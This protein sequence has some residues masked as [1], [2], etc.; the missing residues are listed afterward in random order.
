MTDKNNSMIADALQQAD[1]RL[2]VMVLYHMTGDDIWLGPDFAPGRDVKLIAD[3]QAGFSDDTA[4]LIRQAALDVLTDPETCATP[5]ITDPGDELMVRMMSHCLAEQVP[6]EYAPMMREQ[7]GFIDGLTDL[8]PIKQ[9][10][11]PHEPVLIVGAGISGMAMGV[12]LQKLNIPFEIIEVA[13]EV[14]GTWWYNR[15]PGCGVDTPNHAYSYSYGKPFRWRSYFS[16]REDL[17]TYATG[18]ADDMDLRDN[19]TFNTRV[20]QAQWHDDTNDWA[21]TLK[22]ADGKQTVRRVPYLISCVGHFNVPR[23]PKI[24]GID[25]FAGP[26]FHTAR[27]PDE[28]DLTGK[29]VAIV[30]TGAS[31]MQIVPTIIDDVAALTIV[32]RTPHWVRPVDRF[33]DIISDGAQYLLEHVP[34]Y[35]SWFRFTM[36]W[37][38]GDGLLPFL[39]IDPNWHDPARSLNRGNERH[40]I[41]MT[42]HIE[43]KLEGRPDLLEKC[44]PD[45]PPFGKRI[46]LEN[47][48]FDTLR[49]PKVTLVSGGVTAVTT[50]GVC[51]DDGNV[52]N[53]DVLIWSTGFD[54]AA[55]ACQLNITGMQGQRL[56]DAWTDGTNPTAHLGMT[57][58]GF[59]N[60][61]MM[62]GPNTGLGHGGSTITQAEI[63]ARYIAAMIS[64]A[65]NHGTTRVEV[66]QTAHD[67]YNARLDDEHK[68]LIWQHKGMTTYYRNQAG[69]VY[70]VMPWRI[71]DY[72]QMCRTP[73]WDEFETGS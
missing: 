10:Q 57:V 46:L 61:M 34:F 7:M 26:Q 32:Q 20:T 40:R 41:E 37:R 67:T 28:L 58:P 13:P 55:M 44:V 19:I 72:W 45:Y 30:G 9:A 59:P 2:L 73:D 69:R 12:A 48:W 11:Q 39:R 21:V 56:E 53:A 63:Q 65:I 54:V 64:G 51:T 42:D 70:S 15:Y 43:T 4:R 24:N 66:K 52:H 14:G 22:D 47:G 35:N 6:P 71:V 5:K 16:P 60:M 17:I 8:P 1:L 49:N 62:L 25:D 29:R 31:A 50:T 18:F 23:I 3:E 68:D 33:H 36:M 38:Y 27:W